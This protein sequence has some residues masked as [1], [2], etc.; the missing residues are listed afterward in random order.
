MIFTCL[1]CF[2]NYLII[3][4]YLLDKEKQIFNLTW[5]WSWRINNFLGKQW[6]KTFLKSGNCIAH[7]EANTILNMKGIFSF[8]VRRSNLY[9]SYNFLTWGS[10]SKLLHVPGTGVRTRHESQLCCVSAEWVYKSCLESIVSASF[11][12]C[13]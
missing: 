5:A 1:L 9:W 13:R 3:L 10:C 6:Q 7:A 4:S 12:N 11:V 8:V 2:F